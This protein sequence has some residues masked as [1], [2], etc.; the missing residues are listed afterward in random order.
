MYDQQAARTAARPELDARGNV[1]A[2][3]FGVIEFFLGSDASA[4]WPADGVGGHEFSSRFFL[5]SS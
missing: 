4:E 1:R 3:V 5:F 2:E